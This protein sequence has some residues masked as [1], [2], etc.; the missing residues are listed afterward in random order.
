[1][2][3]LG[4]II[5]SKSDEFL[6]DDELV[7][8]AEKGQTEAVALLVKRYAGELFPYLVKMT[9][10]VQTAEDVFQ[11]TFVRIL[12]KKGKYRGQ[13]NFR[14]FLFTVARNLVYDMLRKRRVRREISLDAVAG[15]EDGNFELSVDE[16]TPVDVLTKEEQEEIVSRA[17]DRLPPKLKEA[18]IL[19]RFCSYSYEN[20]AEM[21]G[22]STSAVK[23]R[24]SRA[25]SQLGK[26]MSEY[27]NE[28][29]T[30]T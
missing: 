19:K 14:A 27:Q 8:K 24:V 17:I 9:G 2:T 28:R 30:S 29:S 12:A 5:V 26:L 22:C 6:G 20:I 18:L 3:A 21:V 4:R 13:G 1:M 10:H 16:T 11:E 15:E 25:L 23:M 7:L